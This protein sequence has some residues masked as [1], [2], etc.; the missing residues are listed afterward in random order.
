MILWW[1]RHH[2][3]LGVI[4]LSIT[5]AINLFGLLVLRQPAA[6]FFHAD[7]WSAWFPSYIAW[8]VVTLLGVGR[9]PSGKQ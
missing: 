8:L 4:G 2:V 6:Q 7:W 9:R 1:S 5:L 3:K